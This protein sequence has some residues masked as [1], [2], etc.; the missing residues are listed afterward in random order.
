VM[1]PAFYSLGMA[2]I[3][4]MI[5]M[6]TIFATVLL[7]FPLMHFF[8]HTGL[9]LAVSIGS[10]LNFAALFLMLRRKIGG[11]GGRR[12]AA[13]GIRILLAASGSAIAAAAVAHA[14]ESAVG[15]RSVFERTL[16]VGVA[17]AVAAAV[18]LGLC[19]LLRVEELKPL[20]GWAARLTGRRGA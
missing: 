4:V 14:M 11:L 5:S 7:Y 15:L 10:I 12:M 19:L 18:Y 6:S 17:L 13:S 8:R 9:A 16:V 3:P 1:V 2:R 20:L